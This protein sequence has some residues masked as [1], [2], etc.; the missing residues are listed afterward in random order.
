[1]YVTTKYG[2]G[3]KESY[4]LNSCNGKLKTVY[5]ISDSITDLIEFLWKITSSFVFVAVVKSNILVESGENQKA[6][7]NFWFGI[8]YW[9]PV[10][11]LDGSKASSPSITV[12]E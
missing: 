3:L 11:V 12:K 1:M 4:S 8:S 2:V 9:L 7:V 10:P 5:C 6:T